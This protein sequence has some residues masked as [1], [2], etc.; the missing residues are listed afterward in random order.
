MSLS[1]APASSSKSAEV[2]LRLGVDD[3]EKYLEKMDCPVA[4]SSPLAK[5]VPSCVGQGS[6]K[7]I[8]DSGLERALWSLAQAR[9]R[10]GWHSVLADTFQEK[11]YEADRYG[12]LY[13]WEEVDGKSIR[14]NGPWKPADLLASANA[15]LQP[16]ACTPSLPIRLSFRPTQF[17]LFLRLLDLLRQ[18]VIDCIQEP[19]SG[20]ENQLALSDLSKSTPAGSPSWLS[21][22][23]PKLLA[24]K[25][26]SLP[27]D[28]LPSLKELELA[29]LLEIR[30]E[31]IQIAPT[32]QEIAANLML[33]SATI[34]LTRQEL[35]ARTLDQQLL[36]LRGKSLW[37]L[38]RKGDQDF[39]FAGLPSRQ[40]A[41]T[42]EAFLPSVNEKAYR[43]ALVRLSAPAQPP[44]IPPETTSPPFN[45]ETKPELAVKKAEKTSPSTPAVPESASGTTPPQ[46]ESTPPRSL[47][48][49]LN[50]IFTQHGKRIAAGAAVLLLLILGIVLG[51]NH[52]PHPS[53]APPVTIQTSS[54][55][56]PWNAALAQAK[57]IVGDP[58]LAANPPKP[59]SGPKD[60]SKGLRPMVAH[61]P[62]LE[63][64]KPPPPAVDLR[65]I[66][67]SS[68]QTD[69]DK[70]TVRIK[71]DQ[72]SNKGTKRSPPLS[73]ELWASKTL[74]TGKEINGY[75]LGE[76]KLK[77]LGPKKRYRDLSRNVT[78]TPPPN[79]TY[80]TS[81]HLVTRGPKGKQ[82]VAYHPYDKAE[83]FTFREIALVGG[84]TFETNPRDRGVKVTFDEIANRRASGTSGT[85]KIQ[86]F[87]SKKPLSKD[88]KQK[89]YFI[90]DYQLGQLNAGESYKNFSKWL[91]Y[92]PPAR[93]K[94][95]VSLVVSEYV[96][97]GYLRYDHASVEKPIK[98]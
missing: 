27:A 90:A 70:L 92:T 47:P 5:F 85:I 79:G 88:F 48:S 13:S 49:E 6:P 65:M 11:T 10:Y 45:K 75:K 64:E 54:M 73:L 33:P 63:K 83:K 35:E 69:N 74:Y 29:D 77:S 86:L 89:G 28:L 34:A 38:E 1:R 81:L 31:S 26:L 19:E 80:F 50:S 17:G 12:Y 23:L 78:Y 71:L 59:R 4:T 55:E 96:Q 44:P 22:T 76:Y 15:I 18:R 91:H 53:G 9:F 8:A 58:L 2:D 25:A 21:S 24:R 97:G 60:W 43:Q 94:Y 66:G 46:K 36:L 62:A 84:F 98:F 16:E 7:R 42:L 14:L 32:L 82:Y 67:A 52:S 56:N 93:G 40:L 51:T 37:K 20:N 95:Y 68:W 30:D 57:P 87:L 39:T 72:I 41:T 61:T 3:L